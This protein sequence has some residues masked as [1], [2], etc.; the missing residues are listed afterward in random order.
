MICEGY[1]ITMHLP[2]D[3]HVNAIWNIWQMCY[4]NWTV[5]TQLAWHAVILWRVCDGHTHTMWRP[6]ECYLKHLRNVSQEHS[7]SCDDLWRVFDNHALT[8]WWPSECYLKHLTNVLQELDRYDT[9]S[10]TLV[11]L[12]RVCD[13]HAHTKWWLCDTWEMCHNNWMVMTQ[14]DIW[15]FCEGTC[16][17]Q[18]NHALSMLWPCE[19]Y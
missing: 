4:K 15:L 13:G 10:L 11:I 19:C 8:M 14:L 1:L 2:C 16:D 12:W 3:D 9:A 17:N 6:C 18:I 7:L 5:M